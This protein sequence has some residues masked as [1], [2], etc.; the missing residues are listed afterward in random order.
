MIKAFII[1]FS[2]RLYDAVERAHCST[3]P[4]S[5]KYDFIKKK[6]FNHK[7]LD[8]ENCRIA[9]DSRRN[10]HRRAAETWAFFF[11]VQF[12]FVNYHTDELPLQKPAF[13]R[14]HPVYETKALYVQRVQI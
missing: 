14:Q 10:G 12:V 13:S 4:N 1:R 5:K 2:L 6:L 8:A 7:P 9:V 11:S 3:A